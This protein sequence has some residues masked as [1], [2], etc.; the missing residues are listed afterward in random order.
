MAKGNVTIRK[1]LMGELVDFSKSSQLGDLAEIELL[2]K[3]VVLLSQYEEEGVALRPEVYLCSNVHDLLKLVTNS[4]VVEIG[5]A[6]TAPEA[7][8][9]ALKRCAPLCIGGWNMFVQASKSSFCYGVFRESLSPL[10]ISV[11]QTIFE[12]GSLP[13]DLKVIK[14]QQIAKNCVSLRNHCGDWHNIFLTDA[15]D[16]SASPDEYFANLTS[17]VCKTADIE[18]SE[19]LQSFLK[20]SLREAVS[21]SHGTL[22]AV[23]NGDELPAFLTD[24]VIL[25]PPIDL[26]NAVALARENAFELLTLSSYAALIKGMISCDGIT[27]F[28]NSGKVLAYCGFI[29]PPAENATA[30]VGGARTRAFDALCSHLG[31]G[32]DAVLVR[33]QDGW[34]QFR[35]AL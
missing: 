7:A 18:I 1:Q 17:C 14:L 6:A 35:K 10:A 28:S 12:S 20:K 32:L 8:R 33:S 31:T 2:A 4:A 24:C 16:D 34:T 9:E 29:K 22:I 19:S 11:D 15:R 25:L 23:A 30:R 3:L 5:K 13:P 21:W 26:A 27:I